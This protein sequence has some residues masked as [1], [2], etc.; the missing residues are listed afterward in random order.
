MATLQ[1]G[2]SSY[3]VFGNPNP[4]AEGTRALGGTERRPRVRAAET[5]DFQELLELDVDSAAAFLFEFYG[6]EAE[7]QVPKLTTQAMDA[8]DFGQMAFWM[9]VAV[10]V[11]ELIYGKSADGDSAGNEAII[12]IGGA[13]ESN[14]QTTSAAAITKG[15]ARTIIKIGSSCIGRM[16]R[17]K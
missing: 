3:T 17:R 2:N 4:A 5:H 1:R 8:G 7:Y 15:I 11:D 13:Q 10:A 12:L 9:D 14:A 6:A 16:L